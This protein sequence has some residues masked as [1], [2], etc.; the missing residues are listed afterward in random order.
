ML[1]RGI[2]PPTR[3]PWFVKENKW[4][5]ARY[6]M[7]TILITNAAGDERLVTDDT[8]DLITRLEP[9]AERLGCLDEL[10]ELDT[11]LERGASYERQLLT[12]ARNNGSL[13]SVVASLVAELRDGL[14]PQE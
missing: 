8:R 9:V 5:A 2:E 14:P 4:R 3:P 10:H 13:K 1:D 7:E 12:A 6:G 11:I